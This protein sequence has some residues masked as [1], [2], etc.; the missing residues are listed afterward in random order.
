MGMD[1]IGKNPK[2]PEGEYFRANVWFWHPLAAYV[3][4]IAPELCSKCEHWH[5]NDGCGL[6]ASDS[7]QLADR[8]QA[9][10]DAG[11]TE[12]YARIYQSEQEATPNEPCRICEGTGTRREVPECGAGDLKNGIKCN[13]CDGEGYRE[14]WSRNYQFSVEA[15]QKFATFLKTSGG[16]GIW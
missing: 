15:V 10:L 3:C 1:V 6:E 12:S 4:S 16:F 9:E 11:R 14:A 5:S 8:L 13:A 2:A 7:I